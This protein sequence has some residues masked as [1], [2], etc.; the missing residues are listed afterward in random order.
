MQFVLEAAQPLLLGLGHP[1]RGDAGG[2]G[3]DLGDQFGGHLG[4][5]G[6]GGRPGV[7]TGLHLGDLVAQ[8]RGLLVAFL[9]DGTVLVGFEP[10]QLLAQRRLVDARAAQPQPGTGLVDQVDRLVRQVPVRQVPHRQVD[11][12]VERVVGVS[13]AVVFGVPVPEAAQDRDRVVVAGF[14]DGD[15]LEAPLERRILLDV[16]AVLVER[17]GADDVQFPA[18][19]L[20]LEDVSGIHR[21]LVAAARADDGVD[22]V[23][24]DDQLVRVRGDLV[25]HL[26]QPL[27]EVAAVPRTGDHAGQVELHDPLAAQA[28]R[29]VAVDDALGE[30][31]DDRGLADPGLADQ[32]R[33]VLGAAGEDL[34]GLLDFVGTA[35]DGVDAAAAG[36]LGQVD[37]ELVQGGGGGLLLRRLGRRTGLQRG[38]ERLRGDPGRDEQA[39]D[40]VLLVGGESH[41]QMLRFDVG[42]AEGTGELVRLEQH[43]LDRAGEGGCGDRAAALFLRESLLHR[44]QD[45]GGIGS[46][47]GHDRPDRVL[48]RHHVQDVERV[49]VRV[50]AFGGES[51]RGGHEF[52]GAT[53][54]VAG[55][56]DTPRATRPEE[57]RHSEAFL[58]DLSL[59]HSTNVAG[60]L[61]IPLGA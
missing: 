15:G 54:Q 31:L 24:E 12:G 39:P 36:P 60:R 52:L 38:L 3:D 19:E 45:L 61:S 8:S 40:P 5:L 13:H 51:G 58:S 23:D 22:F 11:G 53:A 32:H 48:L 50:T 44:S 46:G 49:E 18:G 34:D 43:R 21:A 55:D 27:L 33:V 56:V 30:A 14:A 59:S 7:E 29:D 4:H 10:G 2:A 16:L 6:V 37:T 47:A 1:R 41:E 28:V 20:G 17:G 42:R 57:C 35:D 25:E 9:G 26:G